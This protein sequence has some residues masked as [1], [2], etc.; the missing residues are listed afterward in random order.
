MLQQTAA[1]SLSWLIAARWAGHP[2]PVFAP[3]ATAVGL[4][5]QLGERGSNAVRLLVGVIVGVLAAEG[6]QWVWNTPQHLLAA[7]S[8]AVFV[9]LMIALALTS[10]RIVMAQ[11]AASAVIAVLTGEPHATTYRLIDAL[12]GVGVALLFSQLLLP[13]QPLSTLRSA[14]RRAL[15]HLSETVGLVARA[16]DGHDAKL[17]EQA[18]DQMEDAVAHLADITHVRGRSTRSAQRAPLHRSRLNAVRQETKRAHHLQLLSL[19]CLSLM[20]ALLGPTTANRSMKL[21]LTRG[22]ERVLDSLAILDGHAERQAAG[23]MLDLV[24]VIGEDA[25]DSQEFMH[26]VG[27]ILR[28]TAIDV[29]VF[30]GDGEDEAAVAVDAAWHG[31]STDPE[32]PHDSPPST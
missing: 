8:T 22:L 23:Q 21:T 24:H 25:R 10:E 9:S 4:N 3:I 11:A 26:T 30:T 20:R 19:S 13:A 17:A 12:I 14:E 5:A 7:L 18:M 2:E 15:G 32:G 29:L 1:V 16:L 6:S 31:G 27:A 28:R